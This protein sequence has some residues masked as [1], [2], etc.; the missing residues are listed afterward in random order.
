MNKLFLILIL[1]INFQSWTMADDVKDFEIEGMSVSTSLLEYMSLKEIEKA[2]MNS[3]L[4]PNNQYIVIFSNKS[5]EKYDH[6][7][8][9]YDIKDKD[10]TILSLVGKVLYPDNYLKC[11]NKKKEIVKIFKSSFDTSSID[12][13][14][15][16]H[17]EDNKSLVDTSDFYLKNGGVVRISCTDWTKE[18]GEK[19]GWLDVMKIS[20]S[21]KKMVNYLSTL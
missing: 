8:I 15:D 6:I 2:K 21:N 10:Y 17:Y 16:T 18:L 13:F 4:Y 14:E 20:I 3:T 12:E 7:E 19:F 9:T 5:S 11:K 1:T